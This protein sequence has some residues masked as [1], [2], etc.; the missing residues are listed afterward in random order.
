[1]TYNIVYGDS[2]YKI[3][4]KFNLTVPE[5]K[6]ANKLTGDTIY[7]GSSLFIPVLPD[8][9][10]GIGSRGENI[11]RIQ[12][13]LS[14]MGYPVVIDGI[15]GPI[16]AETIKNIQKKL[17]EIEATGIYGPKTKGLL[18]R[19]IYSGY[20]IIKNPNSILALVNKTN[21]LLPGYTPNDLVI[22]AVPFS[23]EGYD[24][25]K[26]LR[27][28]AARALE[29][30]FAKAKQ[31]NIIL[32]GVSG[33]RSYERQAELYRQAW[34][35]SP[36]GVVTYSARPGESGHQTGLAIDVSSPSVN[37]ELETAFADTKEGQWLKKNAPDFGFIIRYPKGKES[38][39]G[40]PYEPWHIRYVGKGI[41]KEITDRGLTLEE[42]IEK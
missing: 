36:A 5:L 3:A 29:A 18:K 4:Q 22:P 16:I 41:A 39:T 20:H 1:M 15:Y 27:R 32:A 12:E 19:L 17:P 6:T 42:Y 37:Y 9:V 30:L 8:E 13:T 40:Y 26:Q 21:A 34:L 28:E 38:I 2:L 24:P 7:A 25:K 33:F 10:Y 23:F 11:K 31:E 14:H 35:R